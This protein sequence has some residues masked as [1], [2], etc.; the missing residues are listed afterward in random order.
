MRY[1]GRPPL[2]RGSSRP[3]EE[4]LHLGAR[5]G[6]SGVL[7][8]ELFPISISRSPGLCEGSSAQWLG[9]RRGQV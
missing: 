8:G 7:V 5:V 9:L 3:W 6:V 4:D 1:D 2:S